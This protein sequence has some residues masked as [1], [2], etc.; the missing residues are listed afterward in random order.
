MLIARLSFA[1]LL[2]WIG[3]IIWAQRRD[4]EEESDSKDDEDAES[5]DIDN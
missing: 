3:P 1:K 5:E 4:E 2:L